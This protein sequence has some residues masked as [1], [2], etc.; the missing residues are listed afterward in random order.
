M[1]ANTRESANQVSRIDILV[2]DDSSVDRHLAGALL[3]KVEGWHALY[4]GDGVEALQLIEQRLPAVVITD[5]IMPEMGGLELVDAIRRKWPL[6]PVVLMTGHG[7]EELAIQAL[8]HGAASYVPKT[9]LARDLPETVEQVLGAAQAGLQ[10]QRLMESL[11][12]QESHFVL[13]NDPTLITALIPYVQ[14][15]L[16]RL[17]LCDQAERIRVGIA[18]E[19]GLLNGLYHGNLEVSSE[20]RERNDDEYQRLIAERRR[21]P[22]YCHR[23]IRLRT[24][25]TRNE[26]EFT[27]RDEGPG[28]DPNTLPDPTDPS[29][30]GKA[31]G[32]GLLLIRTFMNEVRF[33]AQGNEITMVKHGALSAEPNRCAS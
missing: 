1:T 2:V 13:D 8:R 4:A 21:T 12:E 9:T 24:R 14:E 33:N 10:Q 30:L 32:R 20:L 22:P 18:L 29:N 28:F 5:L 25:V 11:S 23:R 15:S 26:A 16:E 31:S 17:R 3:E 7:S 27:I 6:V 19:E